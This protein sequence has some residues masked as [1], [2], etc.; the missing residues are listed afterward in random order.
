M[1]AQGVN[2]GLPALDLVRWKLNRDGTSCRCVRVADEKLWNKY[3]NG[4]SGDERWALKERP[5]R[6]WMVGKDQKANLLT[7]TKA[8]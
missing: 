4:W 8:E 7:C 1:D 6:W 2:R 3:A 5:E